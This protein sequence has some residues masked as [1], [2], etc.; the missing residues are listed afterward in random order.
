MNQ[1]AIDKLVKDLARP[2]FVYR[3]ANTSIGEA[4]RP[5]QTKRLMKARMEIHNIVRLYAEKELGS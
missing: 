2:I 1:E 5:G 4:P 3:M